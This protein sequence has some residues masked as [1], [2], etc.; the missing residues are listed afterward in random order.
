MGHSY[1]NL[2]PRQEDTGSSSWSMWNLYSQIQNSLVT[3]NSNV[4]DILMFHM[5]E[6]CQNKRVLSGE[7]KLAFLKKSVKCQL[8]VEYYTCH[9]ILSLGDPSTQAWVTLATNDS[10]ALGALVLASSLRRSGTT[11]YV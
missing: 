9:F 6:N 1:G 8:K 4:L 7:Q 5:I 10:Y 11:R 3:T 2:Q